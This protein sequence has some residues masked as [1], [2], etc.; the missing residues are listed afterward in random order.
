MPLISSY[1]D[2][3]AKILGTNDTKKSTRAKLVQ[4]L[5]IN[6]KNT[7]FGWFSRG[8]SVSQLT[9]N[10]L[11]AST[12]ALLVTVT[13][14]DEI[15]NTFWGVVFND[16]SQVVSQVRRMTGWRRS[17]L[18]GRQRALKATAFRPRHQVHPGDDYVFR[19]ITVRRQR[20]SWIEVSSGS[21]H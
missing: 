21:S 11:H 3:S 15:D 20:T 9:V 6:N 4:P 14:F 13:C 16:T 18:R 12:F 8:N 2:N 1:A 5:K 19:T 10:L 17:R 7:R